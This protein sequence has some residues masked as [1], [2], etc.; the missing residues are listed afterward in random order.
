MTKCLFEIKKQAKLENCKEIKQAFLNSQVFYAFNP[1]LLKLKNFSFFIHSNKKEIIMKKENWHLE[2]SHRCTDCIYK[3][4]KYKKDGEKRIRY[5]LVHDCKKETNLEISVGISNAYLFY[6]NGNE[7]E[8][9]FLSKTE[10]INSSILSEMMH[11]IESHKKKIECIIKNIELR[12][13]SCN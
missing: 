10:A 12:N 5:D 11:T 8:M 13:K 6:K 7:A 1:D 3:K 2:S 4:V 9:S